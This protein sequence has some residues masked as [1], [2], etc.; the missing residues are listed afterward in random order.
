MPPKGDARAARGAI[1]LV[2]PPSVS[3]AAAANGNFGD[4]RDRWMRDV[5]KLEP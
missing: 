2:V 1:E 4:K 5:F 3:P